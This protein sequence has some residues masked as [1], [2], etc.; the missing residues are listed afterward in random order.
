MSYTVSFN[1]NGTTTFFDANGIRIDK[2]EEWDSKIQELEALEPMRL[3]R[4]QRD[5]LLASTD[6]WVLPDR[7]VTQEQLEYRQ[8]LRDITNQTPSLDFDG[9]LT[10]ITWPTPPS[11]D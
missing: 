2:P 1:A 7:T 3:L 10:G 9:N 5:Q 4:L 6:W 11:S 8:A